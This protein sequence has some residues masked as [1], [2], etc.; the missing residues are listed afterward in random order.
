M[1]TSSP[2]GGGPHGS[3]SGSEP[4]AGPGLSRRP[5]LAGPASWRP[6]GTPAS[7]L[8]S[9]TRLRNISQIMPDRRQGVMPFP[10]SRAG[11]G[12]SPWPLPADQFRVAKLDPAVSGQE[13]AEQDGAGVV[14]DP[15]GHLVPGP[16]GAACDGDDVVARVGEDGGLGQRSPDVPPGPDVA[17]PP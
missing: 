8:P 15:R 14:G 5:W 13:D 11:A 1:L 17:P 9:E 2:A 3:R 4:A 12:D 7:C 16:V 10:P 6:S